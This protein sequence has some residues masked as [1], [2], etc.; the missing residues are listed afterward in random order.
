MIYHY[1]KNLLYFLQVKQKYSHLYPNEYP[2]KI[3]HIWECEFYLLE[4]MVTY[5]EQ[6][7]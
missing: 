4:V 5:I 7:K 2:Y 6:I 3:Q 1:K